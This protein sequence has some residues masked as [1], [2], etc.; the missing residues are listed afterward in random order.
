[1]VEGRWD[2]VA[3]LDGEVQRA[4]AG[5]VA[6]GDDKTVKTKLNLVRSRSEIE[7]ADSLKPLKSRL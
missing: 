6:V 7:A 1:M 2:A 5:R 3:V 4:A